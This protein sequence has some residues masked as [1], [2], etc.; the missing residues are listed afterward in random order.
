MTAAAVRRDGRQ[1]APAD[2]PG[3]AGA[4]AALALP[5][6]AVALRAVAAARHRRASR[7]PGADTGAGAPRADE[8]ADR[9][10]VSG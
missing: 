2:A 8:P 7:A 10:S 3:S 5:L 4:G 6:Y 9:R 1:A